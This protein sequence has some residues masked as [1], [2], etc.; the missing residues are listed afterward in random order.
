[1]SDQEKVVLIVDDEP[2]LCWALSHLL[3]KCGFLTKM[4]L[5]GQEALF[6]TK[7]ESFRIIF[8]DAKMPD[9]EGFDLARRI[10]EID[11]A[12][13]IIMI[14]GYFSLDNG[15]VQEAL[16]EGL[17]SDCIAKPFRHDEIL[18]VVQ[19]IGKESP[20]SKESVP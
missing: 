4:A 13:R 18:K 2:D 19:R 15:V 11:S 3:E 8:L 10:R 20:G 12:T 6:L 9:M 5:S 16:S 1:M 14:S 7:S 17:I